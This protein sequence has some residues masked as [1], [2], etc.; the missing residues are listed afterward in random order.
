MTHLSAAIRSIAALA[1]CALGLSAAHAQ[2][3]AG[4]VTITPIVSG[5]SGPVGVLTANETPGRVFVIQQG[6][7]IRIV[8][9]PTLLAAAFLDL[10]V[11]GQTLQCR[12]PGD[13]AVSNIGFVSGGEQGLLGLAFHPGF[14]ATG[15]GRGVFFASISDSSG[16]SLIARYTMADPSLDQLTANDRNTCTVILRVDQD[17][18]NHNGGNIVFGPDGFLYFGLGDG[19]SGGD[20][21]NRAQTLDPTTLDAVGSCAADGGFTGNGGDPNSRALLGKMLR[22]DVNAT[23]PAGTTG[24]CGAPRTT[25]PVEYAIPSGQPSSPGGSIPLACDEV[26]A[27]GLRNPW[28][29]SFDRVNGDL[30][31]GDVGQSAW[32]EVNVWRPGTD[33]LGVDFG[34]RTCEA[35]G[36]SGG[37]V[38]SD[39]CPAAANRIN[40]VIAYRN[41]TTCAGPTS[42][43]CSVTGGYRYRG[44]STVLAG[45]YFYG[46]ACRSSIR[47]SNNT[48]GNNWVE[49][50]AAVIVSQDVNNNNLAGSV[51]AFGEDQGGALFFVAGGTLYRIGAASEVPPADLLFRS[52]FEP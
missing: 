16:D 36:A 50:T 4:D 39:S 47:F 2:P 48:G 14:S 9:G 21:C 34:W 28:R 32:E 15:V 26:W 25:Q 43:G 22:I 52:G 30:W 11:T 10:S 17:F 23:T 49:P 40:P 8:R 1:T 27:Y 13:A 20:P 5:I 3:V 41:G 51:L 44:P 18:P 37:S 31:I 24:L 42:N 45:T 29:W 6:G 35:R 33:P 7:E 38:C 19:G 12:Y 46:D